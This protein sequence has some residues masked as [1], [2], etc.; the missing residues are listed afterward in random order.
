MRCACQCCTATCR[1]V[2]EEVTFGEVTAGA[3]RVSSRRVS[4]AP[5]LVIYVLQ[6]TIDQEKATEQGFVNAIYARCIG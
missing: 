4:A 3:G 1:R 6:D 2:A 5:V